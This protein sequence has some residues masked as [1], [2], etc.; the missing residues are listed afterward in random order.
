[1]GFGIKIDLEKC[2]GCGTCYEVCPSE[3]ALANQRVEKCIYSKIIETIALVAWH[4][5]HNALKNA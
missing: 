3:C 2:T 5:K 4:V 1:M